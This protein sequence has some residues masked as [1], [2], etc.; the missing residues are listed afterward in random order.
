M[1]TANS[2]EKTRMLG[3]IEGMRRRGQ[4]RMRWLESITDSMN[5]SLCKIQW[6]VK[7]RECW[8]AAVHG[9]AKLDMTERLNNKLLNKPVQVRC[10][11]QGA[12]GRCT[13]TLRDGMGREVGGGFRMGNTCTQMADSCQCMAKTTTTL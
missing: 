3:K 13:G 7:N 6:I 5:M 2:L 9:V 1:R 12:Q 11:R 4:Q 8:H 10:M